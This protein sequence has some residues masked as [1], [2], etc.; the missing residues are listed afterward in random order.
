MSR[1]QQVSTARCFGATFKE[2]VVHGAHLVGMIAEVSGR[3]RIIER[4]HA[5]DEQRTFVVT[6][7]ERS[8][9]RCTRLAVRH[10]TISKEYARRRRK[11]IGQLTCLAHKTVL[12]FHTIDDRRAV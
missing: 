7:S 4:E 10:E 3:T 2:S 11:A 5:A 9:E 6:G 8:A 12:Y 1:H